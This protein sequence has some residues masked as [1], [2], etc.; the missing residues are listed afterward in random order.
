MI[1][2]DL[3][4]KKRETLFIFSTANSRRNQNCHCSSSKT[5]QIWKTPIAACINAGHTL[6]P[7]R[8]ILL[9]KATTHATD[10][11]HQIIFSGAST[12]PQQTCDFSNQISITNPQTQL[13]TKPITTNI[14][15]WFTAVKAGSATD[16]HLPPSTV[17]S[18]SAATTYP[19]INRLP[20][21]SDTTTPFI[22]PPVPSRITE[23]RFLRHRR[24]QRQ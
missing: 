10:R 18:P 24:Q 11:S 19:L 6:D 21:N 20:S 3:K 4:K 16:R 1:R 14:D 15:S 22:A 8:Q 7:R 9:Q 12:G 17:L 23:P 13:P 5:Q 2:F